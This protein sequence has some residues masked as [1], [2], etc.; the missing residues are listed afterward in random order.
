M[1]TDALWHEFKALASNEGV[2]ANQLVTRIRD[3][4]QGTLCLAIRLFI[5]TKR[6]ET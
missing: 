3:R 4:S 6:T 2:S 5:A 1:I